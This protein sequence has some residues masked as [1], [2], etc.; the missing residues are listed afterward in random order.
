[1]GDALR[2][3]GVMD[4]QTQR[5]ILIDGAP[6]EEMV[7]LQHIADTGIMKGTVGIIYDNG[8]VL[9]GE[10]PCDNGQQSGFTAAAGSNKCYKFPF[11][12]GEGD[13]FYGTGLPGQCVI[14][15]TYIF[16]FDKSSHKK[17]YF[18]NMNIYSYCMNSSGKSVFCS[19]K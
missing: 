15:V 14:G 5:N 3:E 7:M 12:H 17:A 16:K 11:L 10:E 13:I 18:L 19:G 9:R 8:S 1:M 4:L 2:S 6:F